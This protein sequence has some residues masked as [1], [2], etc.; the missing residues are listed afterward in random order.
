MGYIRSTTATGSSA[1]DWSQEVTF[2]ADAAGYGT[3]SLAVIS[4]NPAISFSGTS[5][6]GYGLMFI[7]A[8]TSTGSNFADW[9]Q[10]VAIDDSAPDVGVPSALALGYEYPLIV[11]LDH[12]NEALRYVWSDTSTGTDPA[13][14][15]QPKTIHG[16]SVST[17]PE[18][19]SMSIVNGNPAVSY[20]AD[21]KLWYAYYQP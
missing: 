7:R 14:W 4:G 1:T 15:G 20:Y 6:S 11:Y 21:F 3:T 13:D 2:F 12:T 9:S 17:H 18:G 16:E 19:L 8:T 10:I 5:V